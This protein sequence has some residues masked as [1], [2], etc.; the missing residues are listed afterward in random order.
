MK[1]S[2]LAVREIREN[3]IAMM[4]LAHPEVEWIRAIDMEKRL[5]IGFRTFNNLVIVYP[6]QS[7]DSDVSFDLSEAQDEYRTVP[8]GALCTLD[9]VNK[10]LR[11][12]QE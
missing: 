8:L 12:L 6:M 3:N 7:P 10:Y 2:E 4:K 5:L 11:S 1:F 9:A